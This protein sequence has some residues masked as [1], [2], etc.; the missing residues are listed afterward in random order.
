MSNYSDEFKES[1]VKKA[2]LLDKNSSLSSFCKEQEIGLS[3]IRNRINIHKIFKI[4]FYV[5]YFPFKKR[6]VKSQFRL[7]CNYVFHKKI[8]AN[9]NFKD[10]WSLKKDLFWGYRTAWIDNYLSET[11]GANNS[12]QTWY[13]ILDKLQ[14]CDYN[15]IWSWREE[16]QKTRTGAKEGF[17]GKV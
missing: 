12:Y 7:S 11:F 15:S 13:A 10:V 2:L 4:R 8:V 16:K 5:W 1:M 14:N 3:I 6:K 9:P 17:Y